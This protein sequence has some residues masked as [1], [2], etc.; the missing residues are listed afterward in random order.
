MPEYLL[1]RLLTILLRWMPFRVLYWLSDGLAFLLYRVVGYRKKVV[2][3]NLKRVF[4]EKPDTELKDIARR[5][6]RNLTDVS[7]ETI[8]SFTSPISEISRRARVI[9]PE[10]IRAELAAGKSVLLAGSHVGN[11]EY[12]PLVLPQAL[13]NNMTGVYKKLSNKASDRYTRQARARGGIQPVPMEEVLG[14]IRKKQHIPTVYMLISD[15]S[16]G[17]RKRAQWLP[18]F[19]TET[20]F[21]PGPD[22]ISR[23]FRFPVYSYEIRRVARG[24]YEIEFYPLCLNP[25]QTAE[26]DITRE[27]VKRLE[28]EI[29]RTPENWL[30]S[31]KRWKMKRE[32]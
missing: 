16:P 10:L 7:L 29:R 30:W 19:H 24:F 11:W 8:K 22:V 28:A 23:M 15:Q 26:T 9:N 20:A 25:E 5:F 3:S 13:D 12:P 31:H 18:F 1:L 27:Y 4:P 17:T 2:F 32:G 6:Y 21:L 14:D